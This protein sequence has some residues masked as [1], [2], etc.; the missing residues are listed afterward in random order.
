M[1]LHDRRSHPELRNFQRVNSRLFRGGQPRGKGVARLRDL[2]VRTIV[3]LRGRGRITLAEEKQARALGIRYYRI[4]LGHLRGPSATTI[5]RI[6]NIL[7]EPENWPVYVHC[8]R[9]CDRTGTVVAC[10]RI[11]NDSWTAEKAIAEALEMG[12][13]AAEFLKRAF[14]RRFYHARQRAGA[15]EAKRVRGG[16]R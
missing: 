5:D 2:G 6:L 8:R 11:T 13:Q 10:Y 15:L 12:M 1:T 4:P 3:D 14:I 16:E 7:A 9:G